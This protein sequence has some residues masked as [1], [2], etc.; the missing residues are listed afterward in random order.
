M[1]NWLF[2]L[3]TAAAFL[4]AVFPQSGEAPDLETDRPGQGDSTSLA[5]PG[6]LQVET[7]FQFCREDGG[8]I[9]VDTW[10]GP[11]TLVRFGLTDRLEVRLSTETGQWSCARGEAEAADGFG[12]SRLELS[13]KWRVLE[14]RGARPTVCLLG[15]CGLPTGSVGLEEDG[16]SLGLSV[17]VGLDL[18]GDFS[19]AGSAALAW[20]RLGEAGWFRTLYWAASLGKD[21]GR[22][23][24]A[25]G[26]WYGWDEPGLPAANGFDAGVALALGCDWQLDVAAGADRGGGVTSAFVSAGLC[27]RFPLRSSRRR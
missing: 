1:R 4:P 12:R 3:L 21:L 26:E 25:Y 16:W 6:W 13:G 20:D 17:P 27:F 22:G 10:T 18:P 8:G 14:Q 11:L 23:V 5:L 19:L 2:L 24:S 7:G 15:R 9:R